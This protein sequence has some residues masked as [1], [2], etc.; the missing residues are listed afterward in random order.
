MRKNLVSVIVPLG[1]LLVAALAV[2]V[3]VF[4]QLSS[5]RTQ[6]SLKQYEVTHLEK[7]RIFASFMKGVHEAYFTPIGDRAVLFKNQDALV[8]EY[9]ALEPFLGDEVR[10]AV[11]GTVT[12]YNEF[13]NQAY[14]E[15]EAG[16][17][18]DTPKTFREYRNSLHDLIFNELFRKT[19]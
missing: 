18:S 2:V 13:N 19:K 10:T 12:Q 17:T 5:D 6:V 15:R 4:T 16:I 11:W 7:Q 1:S 9:Y 14:S 8:A 3:P